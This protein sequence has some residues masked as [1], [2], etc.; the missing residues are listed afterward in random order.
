MHVC[1]FTSMWAHLY[2]FVLTCMYV[3]SC[4]NVR[5]HAVC[6]RI[7]ARMYVRLPRDSCNLVG[8]HAASQLEIVLVS[9]CTIGCEASM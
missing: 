2:V 8:E 6:A 7:H 1:V 3:R 4:M 9:A 5:V